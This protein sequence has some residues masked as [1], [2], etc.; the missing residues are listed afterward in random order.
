MI[1]IEEEDEDEVNTKD[2][3]YKC[4]LIISEVV[5]DN[6]LNNFIPFISNTIISD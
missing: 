3:S 1:P 2:S 5:G 6:V 4:L